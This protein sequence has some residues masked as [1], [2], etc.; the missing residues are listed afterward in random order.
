[1]Y[2]TNNEKQQRKNEIRDGNK[3]S[4]SRGGMRCVTAQRSEKNSVTQEEQAGAACQIALH[5]LAKE[6]TNTE[7]A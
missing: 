6:N 4:S 1:M 5:T 7:C 2:E 3:G